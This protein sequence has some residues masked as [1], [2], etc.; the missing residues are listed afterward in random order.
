LVEGQRAIA[1]RLGLEFLVVVVGILSA[2]AVNDWSQARSDRELEEHLLT[3]LAADLEEDRR[4]TER[5][6]YLVQRHRDAVDHLLAITQHTLAPVERQFGDSPEEIDESL[7]VFLDMAELQVFDPTNTEMTS[8]GSIRVIRNR[9]LRRQISTY[10]KTAEEVLAIP[11]RQI[12]P[13]PELLSALAAVGVAPGQAAMMPDLARRLR[14]N[15]AIATHALRM[16]QYYADRM[17]RMTLD[18][19]NEA[20]EALVQSVRRELEA[21]R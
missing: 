21:L 7:I 11:L 20:R 2:L 12:D 10:Y 5:Q 8:T 6:E 17:T 16:R 4:D 19:M 18:Q 9:A 3:S 1:G 13:R 15:P 14:S